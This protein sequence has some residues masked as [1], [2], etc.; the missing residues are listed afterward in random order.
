M[1]PINLEKLKIS[2]WSL[3]HWLL[4][5]LL[6]GVTTAHSQNTLTV[7]LFLFTSFL[8]MLFHTK[9]T[10]KIRDKLQLGQLIFYLCTDWNAKLF[11]LFIVHSLG[12]ASFIQKSTAKQHKWR[13][14]VLPMLIAA[15]IRLKEPRKKER[16]KPYLSWEQSSNRL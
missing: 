13:T 10:H 16:K 8:P 9:H 11:L 1:L 2:C 7:L 5:C 3:A 15:H 12:N 6:F 14:A 4:I